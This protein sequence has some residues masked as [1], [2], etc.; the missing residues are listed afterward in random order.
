MKSFRDV[1]LLALFLKYL[2]FL[3]I[4]FS[5]D[6]FKSI[7]LLIDLL[8]SPLD[9]DPKS[10]FFLLI[11]NSIFILDFVILDIASEIFWSL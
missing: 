2:G 4:I 11:T 7:F 10:L 9:I 3:N 1:K 6:S 8:K 5:T